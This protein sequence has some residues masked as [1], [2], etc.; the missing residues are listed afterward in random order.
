MPG[1]GRDMGGPQAQTQMPGAYF[2]QEQG[3]NPS[4]GP[5]GMVQPAPQQGA[6]PE[7]AEEFDSMSSSPV[8]L[9]NKAVTKMFPEIYKKL[10]IA[11]G[12][13]LTPAQKIAVDKAVKSMRN[14]LTDHYA[15]QQKQ[16][17]AAKKEKMKGMQ[18]DTLSAK[19]KAGFINQF[20][21]EFNEMASDPMTAQNVQGQTAE[22]YA[23][24]KMKT[25]EAAISGEGAIPEQGGQQG[26]GDAMGQAPMMGGYQGAMPSPA[27]PPDPNQFQSEVRQL[28]QQYGNTPEG[29]A[30]AK[31]EMAKRYPMLNLQ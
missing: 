16:I 28:L 6:I 17:G 5:G 8:M 4:M 2:I 15:W 7:K 12:T 22:Q 29:V 1:G 31:Q 26:W 27:Q 18:K 11:P 9:A 25:I 24:N 19:D 14:A 23:L 21:N 30:R 3:G 13:Q 10:G 20:M